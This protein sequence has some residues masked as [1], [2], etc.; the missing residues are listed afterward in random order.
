MQSTEMPLTAQR[1]PLVV[2]DG[3]AM[4]MIEHEQSVLISTGQGEVFL[5]KACSCVEHAIPKHS[6]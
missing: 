4:G 6:L 1:P 5:Q 2:A 3:N